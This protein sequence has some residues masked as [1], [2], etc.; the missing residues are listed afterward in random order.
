[1]DIYL[2]HASRHNWDAG[3]ENISGQPGG[4]AST[5]KIPI[6]IQHGNLII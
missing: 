5:D 4:Q 3:Q 1:M 6:V 2:E